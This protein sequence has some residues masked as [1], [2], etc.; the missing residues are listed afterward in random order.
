MSVWKPELFLKLYGIYSL[1]DSFYLYSL[2][3]LSLLLVAHVK[4]IEMRT[5]SINDRQHVASIYTGHT[6]VCN[7]LL[8]HAQVTVHEQSTNHISL[9]KQA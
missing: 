9:I 8:S 4:L 2:L 5:C 1:S 3:M 6:T 7:E